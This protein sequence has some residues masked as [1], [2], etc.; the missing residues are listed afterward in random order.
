MGKVMAFKG[1]YT[2]KPKTGKGRKAWERYELEHG[3]APASVEYT[4]EYDYEYKGWV[5]ERFG[6][7]ISVDVVS[8][9]GASRY[10]TFYLSKEL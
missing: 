10:M 1:V 2:E 6:S 7:D 5:C 3:K 9:Y 8:N 4:H